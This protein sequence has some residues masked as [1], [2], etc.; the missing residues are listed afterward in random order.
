M[1][2][3]FVAVPRTQ[4]QQIDAVEPNLPRI[5]LDQPK[6]GPARGC[7]AAA[8]FT[9]QAEG[10]AFIDV[11]ADIVDRLDVGRDARKDAS[12]NRKVLLEIADAQERLRRQA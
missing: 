10:F 1:S 6:N 4:R 3:R 5:R 2:R 11:E 8:G 12:T 7:F 9:D